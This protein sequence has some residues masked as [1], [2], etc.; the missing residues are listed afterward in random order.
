MVVQ[1]TLQLLVRQ[2]ALVGVRRGIHTFEDLAFFLPSLLR[3]TLL[4]VRHSFSCGL[5]RFVV[6]FSTSSFSNPNRSVSK[7]ATSEFV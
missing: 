5:A 6:F 4:F 7:R 3:F 2:H 1:Q